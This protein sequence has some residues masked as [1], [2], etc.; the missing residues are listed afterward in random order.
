M[1]TA[2]AAELELEAAGTRITISA[3]VRKLKRARAE[4][5][6]RF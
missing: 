6:R 5:K 3:V 2:T 4:L 1:A